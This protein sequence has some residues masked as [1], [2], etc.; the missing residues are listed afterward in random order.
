ALLRG[1]NSPAV[2]CFLLRGLSKWNQGHRNH[3]GTS[4]TSPLS[5]SGRRRG[6]ASGHDRRRVP[7]PAV[8]E[9]GQLL[10]GPQGFPLRCRPWERRIKVPVRNSFLQTPDGA[11]GQAKLDNARMHAVKGVVIAIMACV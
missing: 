2:F 5:G 10:K 9:S 8:S 6:D 1:E 11:I 7:R 3:H 4:T